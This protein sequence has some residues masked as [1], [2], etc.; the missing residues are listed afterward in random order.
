METTARTTVHELGLVAAGP[1]GACRD[2]RV[3]Y[4]AD[5]PARELLDAL[6]DELGLDGEP[7]ARRAGEELPAEAPAAELAL[8]HGDEIRFGDDTPA[9]PTIP[10]VAELVVTGGP[11]A[12]RRVPLPPGVHRVGREASIA[13]EDPSLSAQHLVLTIGADGSATVADAGSRNGTLVEG[14]TLPASE[15][16]ELHAGEHVQ[17]GRTLLA[18][19]RPE[20]EVPDA[21]SD[22]SGRVP[23]NRPPRVQRPL[24]ATTRP[25][26]APPG[27]PQRS[28]LP[29]GASLIPLA[30]GIVLY[31]VTKLPTMLLFSLLSPVMALSTYIEDRRSGR[32]GFEK[33]TA[34]VPRAGSGPC[35][36]SSRP[37]GATRSA[38]GDERRRPPPELLRR[39][40]TARA[41]ALG[42][43]AGR[44]GLPRAAGR[45]RRPRRRS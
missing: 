27:D 17:A 38:G 5:A 22:R 13:I 10:A 30:L 28:R 25:F 43:A 2:V 37:S 3:E 31:A 23:F 12:G 44:P 40:R 8:R 9:P 34:G 33:H 24:E 36:T 7:A 4:V 35:A 19:E 45:E 41:G 21:P 6:A 39:A 26:P 15:E 18:V 16:R 29:L 14:V 11:Q 1:D 42:A 20:G 32:K